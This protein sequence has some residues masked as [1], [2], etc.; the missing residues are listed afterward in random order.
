MNITID[1]GKS[2]RLLTGGKYCTEDI[3][4]TATSESR[5]RENSVIRR[6]VTEY[7]NDE[8]PDI[9]GCIFWGSKVLTS[10]DFQNVITARE[11]CFR[12]CT[13]LTSVNLPSAKYLYANSFRGCTALTE[14]VFPSVVLID[15]NAFWDCTSIEKVDLH[16]ATQ[17]NSG[18]FGNN[19][20]LK[21]LIMRDTNA[22][23]TLATVSAFQGTPFASDGSGSG[24]TAYVH[25][26]LLEDY[27]KATN[28]SALNCTFVKLE[29]SEYE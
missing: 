20:S 29:G 28:W 6:T 23:A 22:V 3:V 25:E 15:A 8:V 27:R 17:L 10:V 26:S 5:E 14:L 11:S 7:S 19:A 24:G 13:A 2:K 16:R 9:G 12:E 18:A 4:V 21:V 1:G